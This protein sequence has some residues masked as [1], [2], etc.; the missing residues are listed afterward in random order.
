MQSLCRKK[1]HTP[2]KWSSDCE[3]MFKCSLHKITGH[4]R[5]TERHNR[6]HSY[7]NRLSPPNHVIEQNLRDRNVTIDMARLLPQNMTQIGHRET[8]MS[9][10]ASIPRK[11]YNT[12]A[13]CCDAFY[14]CMRACQFA[15][16]SS[17]SLRLR[18]SSVMVH[19]INVF[20]EFRLPQ[21]LQFNILLDI[22]SG[23]E[24]S[25]ENM[26]YIQIKSV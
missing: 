7:N 18:I 23:N 11:M 25:R 13:Y 6:H 14:Y 17:T 1:I 26:S 19:L 20:L 24:T 22:Y 10:Q 21:W 12:I 2:I 3:Q 5:E 16:F 8:E 4:H 15:Q 9:Q